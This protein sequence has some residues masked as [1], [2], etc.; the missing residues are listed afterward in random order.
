MQIFQIHVD[1]LVMFVVADI[2]ISADGHHCET[3]EGT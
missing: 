1:E 3:E 2:D